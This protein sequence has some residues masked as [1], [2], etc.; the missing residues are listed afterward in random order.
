MKSTITNRWESS[1]ILTLSLTCWSYWRPISGHSLT[2]FSLCL[3][4]QKYFFISAQGVSIHQ[5]SLFYVSPRTT[6]YV[7][8]TDGVR[9]AHW[10]AILGWT[11]LTFTTSSW[12]HCNALCWMFFSS[13]SIISKYLL[14]PLI[15]SDLWPDLF[16]L[17]FLFLDLCPSASQIVTLR[18][19]FSFIKCL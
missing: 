12:S 10:G 16:I 14:S 19:S 7:L 2:Y 8:M 4:S 3:L 1:S 9:I 11:I 18:L 5:D 6:F 17:L 13:Y 15:Q